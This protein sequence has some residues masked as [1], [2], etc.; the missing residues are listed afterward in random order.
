LIAFMRWRRVWRRA[1]F[2]HATP[3]TAVLIVLTVGVL[4]APLT[5]RAQPAVSLPRIGYLAPGYPSDPRVGERFLQAFRQGLRQLGYVEGQNIVIEFRSAEGKYDRLSAL[6]TELIRFKVNVIVA[7]A[8]P[9]TQAAK[10]ATKTIP[11]VMVNVADPVATGFVAS[12]ARP[13]GNV[14]GLSLM[15]PELVAKQLE[16]LKEVVPK[17]SRVALLWNPANPSNAPL[18]QHAQDAARALKVLL[19][20]L[21]A[22]DSTEIDSAFAATTAERAGAVIVLTESVTLDHRTRIADHTVRRQLP[23]VFGVSE[24]AEAGGLLAYG[25]SLADGYRRAANYVDMILKGAKPADLPV[26]QPTTFE[27]VVNLKTAKAIGLTIPPSVLVR[28][29]Q[30]LE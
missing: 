6:A 16:L 15:L 2:M 28:A 22:R 4:A 11:I 12:L 3:F 1:R 30:I 19:Q 17:V 25:P 29:D 14:T 9:A 26:A 20:L 23:T 27:L 24:F 18:V 5:A 8:S 10:Q 7:P 21:E 13:G